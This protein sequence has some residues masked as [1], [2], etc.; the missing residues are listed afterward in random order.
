MGFI[1]CTYM[2]SLSPGKGVNYTGAALTG[3]L[4]AVVGSIVSTRIMLAF[5]AKIYGR[6]QPMIDGGTLSW[7]ASGC[8]PSGPAAPAPA[9]CL[10]C[11]TAAWTA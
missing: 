7:G 11:W 2:I 3:L 10:P 8:V 4:G 9:S 6:E 5:T 1:V